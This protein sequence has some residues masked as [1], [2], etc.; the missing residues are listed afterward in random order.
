MEGS[1]ELWAAKFPA[2][3]TGVAWDTALRSDPKRL[4][5]RA[6]IDFHP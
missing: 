1:N 3:Q 5:A 2:G 4:R 6:D